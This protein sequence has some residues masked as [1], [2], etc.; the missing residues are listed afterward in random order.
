MLRPGNNRNNYSAENTLEKSLLHT[1]DRPLFPALHAFFYIS[2]AWMPTDNNKGALY[3]QIRL[4][5]VALINKIATQGGK[6]LDSKRPW[7]CHTNS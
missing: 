5:E 1:D 6:L 2:G 3:L 4:P 7:Y